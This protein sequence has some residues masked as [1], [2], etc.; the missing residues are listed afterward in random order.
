MNDRMAPGRDPLLARRPAGAQAV[1]HG[2]P[3][4]LRPLT[5][6]TPPRPERHRLRQ[7]RRRRR[8]L[9][10]SLAL[11]LA[12]GAGV[13][14]WWATTSV[15]VH[16][17]GIPD[18]GALTPDGVAGREVRIDVEGT[19]AAQARLRLNGQPLDDVTVD[20]PT[21]VWHAPALADGTYHLDVTIDR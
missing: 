13:A 8:A 10:A 5:P 18:A 9:V 15:S 21:L 14:V 1:R 17:E 16:L 3:P 2:A 12:G 20:G 6:L 7:R 19:S 11:V 4:I